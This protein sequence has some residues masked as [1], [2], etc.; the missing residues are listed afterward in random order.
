METIKCSECGKELSN[1]AY[2]CP[3]CGVKLKNSKV[4]KIVIGI[5]SIIGIVILLTIIVFAWRTISESIL[6]NR[7]AGD[8]ILETP[9]DVYLTSAGEITNDP[10]RG[11]KILFDETLHIEKENVYN[12]LGLSGCSREGDIDKF[13]ERC[14]EAPA[15][16]LLSS[17]E[18]NKFAINF[19]NDFGNP[20][21]LCFEYTDKDTIEQ[22]S[23]K[24]IPGDKYNPE[25]YMANGGLDAELGITYKKI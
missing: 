17:E 4:E 10:E 19:I 2:V 13:D 18:K 9:K 21:L 8:W 22:I 23:C 1:K 5:L 15:K 25:L 11:N 12:G 7:Y 20:V 3:N 24:G 6:V 14:D 16:V